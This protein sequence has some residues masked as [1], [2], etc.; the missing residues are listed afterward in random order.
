M[1]DKKSRRDSAIAAWVTM[2]VAL[3]LLLVLYFGE[4]G[5]THSRM[6]A[7]SVPEPEEELFLDPELLD[8]GEEESSAEVAPSPAPQGAP[9]KSEEVTQ[10]AVVKGEA[11]K[12][13]P[14]KEKKVTGRDPS[15]V[16][17][18]EPQ[19]RPKE[20]EKRVKDLTA[21]AF[22]PDN[23]R[24]E[25]RNDA[26]G[27]GGSSSG[28]SGFAEGREFISCPKPQVRLRNRTVVKVRVTVE[29][30]GHVSS[31]KAV[32]GGDATLR[33]RCERA[34]LGARWKAKEGAKPTR[35]TITFTL[36][37]R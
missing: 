18:P 3:V 36:I 19:K 8:L 25:G 31:A 29:A 14:P 11:E 37:P 32:S 26:G 1:G 10:Q 15:P 24:A 33:Q 6:A 35:G 34:A 28:I 9:E 17:A 23:G 12:P 4:I 30:S 7:L 5:F 16:K 22:S 13:A 27:T 2:L 20:E 21:G